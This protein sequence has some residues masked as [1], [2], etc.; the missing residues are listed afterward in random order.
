MSELFERAY[1]WSYAE[2]HC[3]EPS[4]ARWEYTPM[5]LWSM[6]CGPKRGAVLVKPIGFLWQLYS[7][8][9]DSLTGRSSMLR[10]M[11]SG[12]IA[13]ATDKQKNGSLCDQ[14]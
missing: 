10:L 2:Q 9:G 14:K 7:E 11:F 6:H 3:K 8:P 12:I 4:S 5:L 13:G 1:N